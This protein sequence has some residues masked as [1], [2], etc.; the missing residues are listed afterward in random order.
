MSAVTPYRLMS[1]S[2]RLTKNRLEPGVALPAGAAAQLVVDAPALVPVR[3]D[4]VEAAERRQLRA[5][6]PASR[7]PRTM[8]VPRPAMFVEIVTAPGMP[9][10]A[11]ITA[12]RASWR[13]L[14]T[15]HLTRRARSARTSASDSATLAVPTRTG[16]P[17]ACTR[18]ISSE[19]A[20]ILAPRSVKTRSGS[21]TR[22]HGRFGG[23]TTVVSP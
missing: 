2:S 8:S 3:A 16:R 5:N 19:R 18:A 1:S 14:S 13:A 23:K 9:A 11:T 15:R 20:F 6:A 17:V 4:D 12:S 7:P 21:S 10:L 22:L